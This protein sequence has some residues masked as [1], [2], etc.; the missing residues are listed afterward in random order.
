MGAVFRRD[1]PARHRRGL[2][3]RLRG[4]L[5]AR[6]R[7]RGV[8]AAS[9]TTSGCPGFLTHR[10]DRPLGR[11]DRR[12]GRLS[13]VRLQALPRGP[14]PGDWKWTVAPIDPAWLPELVA[15]A[16]RLGE[17]TAAAAAV[18][19]LPA[20]LPVIAAAA[21]KACE[22]LGSGAVTPDVVGISYGTAATA[23]ITSPRYVEPIPLDPAVPGGDPRRLDPRD[24]GLSRLLDGRVV[25]ARVRGPRGRRGR[26][27]R[28]IAP[29]TL[30]EELPR[31][32]PAGSDG[33]GAPAVLVTGRAH[34][35]PGGAGRDHRVQRGPHPGPPVPGDARRAGLRPARGRGT[36]GRAAPASRSTACASRAAGHRVRPQCS[37]RRTCSGSRWAA[38][39]R[40]RR[41]PWA[42]PSTRRS[43]LGSIR[44][45]ASAAEAMIHVAETASPTRARTRATRSCTRASTGRCTTGSAR[46]TGVAASAERG[47]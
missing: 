43:A 32:V 47:A 26:N 45:V 34:P 13:A 15:P 20:G 18:T 17:L 44:D 41:R 1:R 14:A 2:R 30:F 42:R 27:A 22:V 5:A 39:T 21:D 12:A 8:G 10:L 11:L 37:S 23:N 3:R 7:A 33:P 16:A 9:A 25:Q 40:T 35:R 38:P 46:S 6:G 19:G 28:G 31:A 29:E 24:P 4:E 36:H